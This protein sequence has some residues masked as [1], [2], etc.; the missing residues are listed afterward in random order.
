MNPPPIRNIELEFALI[1]QIRKEGSKKLLDA[2]ED[3]QIRVEV[4][5]S[6]TYA[7]LIF[8]DRYSSRIAWDLCEETESIGLPLGI[9]PCD[10]RT[11]ESGGGK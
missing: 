4:V 5:R 2:L 3:C 6:Y 8:P 9:F 11:L 7:V 10:S 1:S